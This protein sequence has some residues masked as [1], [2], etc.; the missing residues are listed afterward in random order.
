MIVPFTKSSGKRITAILSPKEKALF[1]E[2]LDPIYQKRF[3]FLYQT[4]MRLREAEYFSQHPEIFKPE[5]G[6][7]ALPHVDG[8]GKVRCKILDRNILLSKKGLAIV[9]DFIDYKITFPREQSMREAC[10]V[11][12]VKADFRPDG[13]VPKM[14]RKMFISHA[15]AIMPERQMQLALSVGHDFRTMQN[16][17]MILGWKKGDIEDMKVELAGLGESA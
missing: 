14:F 2:H 9:Q 15:M 10:Q 7:I 16:N 8:M 3:D 17:Y 4:A 12:A 1:F 13:I 5:N 6:I 11:A